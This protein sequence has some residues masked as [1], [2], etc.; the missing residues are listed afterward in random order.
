MKIP[1]ILLNYN[2]SADCKKC[3]T[4]LKQQQGIE[5]EIVI[6]DNCSQMDESVKVKELSEEQG[7]TFIQ[8]HENRGYNAGN[9][10]G[11]RYA[12]EKGYKYALIA[13]P[14]MEF[15]QMDYIKKLI[16]VMERNKEVVVC[17]S[18]I[19]GTDSSHQNPWTFATI[20]DDLPILPSILH[21]L[22]RRERMPRFE[23]GYCDIVTGCCL[24]LRID[25]ISLVGYLDE[26][27]FLYCEEAILG[28]QVQLKGKKTYYLHEAQAI[29][30][31]IESAKGSF[32]KRHHIFWQSRWYYLKTYSR[33]SKL[34]LVVIYL[35]RTVYY[36]IKCAYLTIK[37]VK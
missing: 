5:L 34:T 30:R 15:P 36:H 24:L 26:N 35:L 8:A 12:A 37:G 29:H 10:I 11:L 21:L 23:S 3:V 27:V 1:V 20:W 33:Y 9:N 4:F 19:I 7:C 22:G 17:G 2:S 6:V 32:R 14:D 31:H 25:F 13:N 16:D 28:K 18:D